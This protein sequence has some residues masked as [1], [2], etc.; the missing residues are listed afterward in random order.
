MP[1]AKES[2][3]KLIIAVYIFHL[4]KMSVF[5]FYLLTYLFEMMNSSVC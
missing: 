2:I 4:Y 1:Q 3:R 5:F